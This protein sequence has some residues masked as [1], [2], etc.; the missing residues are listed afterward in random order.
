MVRIIFTGWWS[1]NPWNT[2]YLDKDCQ[3]EAISL[4][5]D[6][7]LC[8]FRG[9]WYLKGQYSVRGRSGASIELEDETHYFGFLC[10]LNKQAEVISTCSS[11]KSWMSRGNWVVTTQWS[12]RG[13]YFQSSG[14]FGSAFTISTSN[15]KKVN[16]NYNN[17]K[18][19]SLDNLD[20]L[21]LR[22]T[23]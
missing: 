4:L 21:K 14:A 19:R 17:K 20:P 9:L 2:P 10:R 1:K 6:F 5:R 11:Y 3:L 18:G 16:E 22:F 8:E 23:W 12:Q 13:F 15:R 7:E